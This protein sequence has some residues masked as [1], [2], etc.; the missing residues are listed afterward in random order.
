[1]LLA[2]ATNKWLETH[3]RTDVEGANALGCVHL[4]P[5]DGEQVN[6]KLGNIDG[7]LADRLGGIGVQQQGAVLMAFVLF[8]VP[9]PETALGEVRRVLRAAGSVGLT[10]WGYDRGAPALN[11][12]NQELDRHGAPPDRPLI[13]QHDLMNT[14]DKLLAMLQR[15][16][17]QRAEVKIMPWSHQASL[18]QFIEQ[19]RT[20]GVTGRRLAQ[21]KPSARADFLRN[22]RLRLESLSREDFVD[23][24]EVL[25]ATATTR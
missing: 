24:G 7:E 23:H 19:H 17:F 4:V 8:H 2:A 15:S 1:M 10:T 20:L 14:P 5:D 3:A 6:V 13:A 22:V 18:R 16:G 9:E 12:W 25:I 21:L 11:I